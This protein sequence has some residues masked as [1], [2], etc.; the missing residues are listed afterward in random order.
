ML[1]QALFTHPTLLTTLELIGNEI[2]GSASFVELSQ[3][4]TL[5][6]SL[7]SLTLS[8]N[9]LSDNSVRQLSVGL[10]ESQSL[11]V[12]QPQQ[13]RPHRRGNAVAV[14][15]LGRQPGVGEARRQR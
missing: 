7:S 14:C 9:E 13:Q 15:C 11:R 1:S 2:G 10:R 3:L 6:R 4:L 12:A 8:H 5:T